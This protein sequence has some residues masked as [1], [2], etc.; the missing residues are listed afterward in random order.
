[1]RDVCWSGRPMSSAQTAQNYRA[2]TGKK[3]VVFALT[4]TL[5]GDN[6]S[7]LFEVYRSQARL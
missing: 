5:G 2:R 6:N 1:M 3:V 7:Q 4:T